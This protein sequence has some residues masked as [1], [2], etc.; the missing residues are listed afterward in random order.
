MVNE[1][2]CVVLGGTGFVGR[3]LVARMA[4][5]GY[6]V[7]VP[8]R[9]LERARNM[10]V[11][12]RVKIVTADVHDP[13]S[14]DRL[15][16]NVDVVVN[17]V[18]ILNEQGHHGG[19]GFYVAHE[20]LTENV[21]R[22][23]KKAGVRRLLQMSALKA[24]SKKGPSD[25]L[26]SK[27]LAEDAIRAEENGPAWTIFQPSV[28]FGRGDSFINRF[29][30]LLKISPFLPLARPAARFSPV[31]VEDV[32]QAFMTA[33]DDDS[34]IGRT[35]QLCGPKVYSLRE[36][37]TYVKDQ[38]G[39][40]RWIV[41]LP[42]PLARIQ[43]RIFDFVPGKPLSTDNLRSLMVHSICDEN[44]LDMLGIVPTPMETVVPTYLQGR[45]DKGR[46][47]NLRRNH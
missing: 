47:T 45:N 28:I 41:G 16:Q 21:L 13:D 9:N 39:L 11:T 14:L 29:A 5:R 38:L 18:G 27:G 32:T 12:P 31:Y 6:N 30:Q 2:K 10:A 25:Y 22:A 33:L 34:T 8:T 37:V 26:K 43:A 3:S 1:T 24:D 19:R 46:L 36:L 40:R 23:A 44:G 35:Y 17:L 4:E 7:V 20:A 15:L 42:D